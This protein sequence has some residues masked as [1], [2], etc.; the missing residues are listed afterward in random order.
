MGRA[1]YLIAA[2]FGGLLIGILSA[3]SA[4]G[5]FGLQ[6]VTDKSAWAEWQLASG[7]TKLTYTLGHFLSGG[8]LPPPKLAHSFVRTTDDSG[9]RLRSD[10]V[11]L[12]EGKITPARWWTMSVNNAGSLSTHSVL[13]AG[14]AIVGEEDDLKVTISSRPMPG[15]WLEPDSSSVSLI[16]IIN[17]APNGQDLQ[18]PSVIKKGC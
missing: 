8:Q 7:D 6:P 4:L 9:A 13:T 11:Y 2:I 16:Y 5:S 18:L 3:V 12:V 10:C 14:E 15:N 17:E 1:T